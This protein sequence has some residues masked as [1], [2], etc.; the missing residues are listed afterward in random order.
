MP[1][2]AVTQV[3]AA[4]VNTIIQLPVHRLVSLKEKRAFCAFHV[5]SAVHI[6]NAAS[7]G[8]AQTAALPGQIVSELKV[9]QNISRIILRT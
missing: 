8:C 2:T 4:A 9:N 7:L 6:N 5:A 1:L 3:V